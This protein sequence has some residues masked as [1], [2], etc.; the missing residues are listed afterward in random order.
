MWEWSGHSQPWPKLSNHLDIARPMPFVGSRPQLLRQSARAARGLRCAE[1]AGEGADITIKSVGL[2][3]GCIFLED[4]FSLWLLQYQR[5]SIILPP[6][7]FLMMSVKGCT[8]APVYS[9]E[10]QCTDAFCEMLPHGDNATGFFCHS[11]RF[12][13]RAFALELVWTRS[14]T[15]VHISSYIYTVTGDYIP[16]KSNEHIL[17]EIRLQIPTARISTMLIGRLRPCLSMAQ[18]EN[19][20]SA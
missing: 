12:L 1:P 8:F 9:A 5:S 2:H 13:K 10:R 19:W 14:T 17:L 7:H 3:I 16:T 6:T 15:K 4:D 11:P 18:R 20:P